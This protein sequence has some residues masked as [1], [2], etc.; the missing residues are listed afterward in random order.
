M[1]Q[2]YVIVKTDSKQRS[3]THI[4]VQHFLITSSVLHFFLIF[5]EKSSIYIINVNLEIC[6]IY[7]VLM[8]KPI[9]KLCSMYEKAVD[10]L[11]L[12]IKMPSFLLK[13]V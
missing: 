11:C 9:S 13:S 10:I 8:W 4:G 12:S 2:K 3:T 1:L 7:A 6:K 5:F